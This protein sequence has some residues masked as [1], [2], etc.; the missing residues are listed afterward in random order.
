MRLATWNIQFGRGVDGRVDL[1]RVVEHLH[2]FTEFDVLCLQEVAIEA[3]VEA[4]FDALRVTTTHLETY[5]APQRMAQID[6]LRELQREG[7]AHARTERPGL[8]RQGAF[9][10]V[11]RGAGSVLAGDMNFR[12]GTPEHERLL[13][14][15]D[16]VSD[17]SDHQAMVLEL[18]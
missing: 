2:R 12:P 5:S 1:E 3:T 7:V 6:R 11:P 4:P 8:A 9:R 10:H 13:A 14:T 18:A 16:A 15:I 17:V